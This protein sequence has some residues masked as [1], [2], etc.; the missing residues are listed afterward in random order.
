MQYGSLEGIFE[1]SCLILGPAREALKYDQKNGG[2]QNCGR[3][4]A[5]VTSYMVPLWEPHGC[6]WC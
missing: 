4:H 1:M 6:H 3:L 2:I 5:K